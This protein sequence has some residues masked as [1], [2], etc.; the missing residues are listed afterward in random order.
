MTTEKYEALK[1]KLENEKEEVTQNKGRLKQLKETAKSTFKVDTIEELV[2]LKADLE[3][4]LDMQK[5]KK[6]KQIDK[7]ESIVPQDVLNE[8]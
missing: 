8:L 4:D 2:K 3:L 1:T 5:E 6:K 7:L